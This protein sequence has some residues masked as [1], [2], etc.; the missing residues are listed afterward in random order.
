MSESEKLVQ[1]T[2]TLKIAAQFAALTELGVIKRI[3]FA[4]SPPED[5]GQR[6]ATALEDDPE[7]LVGI[8]ASLMVSMSLSLQAEQHQHASETAAVL[9]PILE[10]LEALGAPTV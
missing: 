3:A 7:A 5:I 9:Q 4:P 1:L 6:I 2:E 10:E 8:G